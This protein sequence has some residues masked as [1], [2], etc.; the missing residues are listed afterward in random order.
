MK[1]QFKQ[2]GALTGAVFIYV[3]GWLTAALVYSAG[4]RFHQ[5]GENAAP[6]LAS[7]RKLSEIKCDSERIRSLALK[8]AS[9]TDQEGECMLAAH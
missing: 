3:S 2:N 4:I 9:L 5:G 7:L 1:Q 8:K 6:V